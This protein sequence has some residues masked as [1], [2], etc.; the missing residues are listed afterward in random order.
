MS[1]VIT[2]C[3]SQ[4]F[5]YIEIVR[6]TVF[7]SNPNVQ[8]LITCQQWK[9]L[10]KLAVP[11]KPTSYKVTAREFKTGGILVTRPRRCWDFV[12]IEVDLKKAV[13]ICPR[14]FRAVTGIN[15]KKGSQVMIL[16]KVSRAKP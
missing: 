16:F 4:I 5:G 6:G 14:A 11:V 7:K 1:D 10:T 3:K 12:D 9:K 8:V 2:A 15:I 13:P